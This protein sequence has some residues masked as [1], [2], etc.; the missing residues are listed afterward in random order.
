[1]VRCAERRDRNG[2]AKI[3]GYRKPCGV[4]SVL[5]VNPLR[6]ICVK[7]I[8]YGRR[9]RKAARDFVRQ[10]RIGYPRRFNRLVLRGINS[11]ENCGPSETLVVN[12]DRNSPE[13]K[14]CCQREGSVRL[15][16]LDGSS[17]RPAEQRCLEPLELRWRRPHVSRTRSGLI[18]TANK[19]KKSF[20]AQ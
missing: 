2:I 7:E 18:V 16:A 9:R 14:V 5:E 4:H 12:I 17:L 13:G 19:L 11:V 15:G 10:S 1:M 6:W 8:R 3:P 20:A